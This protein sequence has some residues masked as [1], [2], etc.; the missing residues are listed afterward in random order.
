[1]SL[2]V[3]VVAAD[4]SVW[5]GDAERVV[6]RTVEG[7]IGILTGHE[8]VLAIVA[9]GNVRI[10]PTSGETINVSADGGFL[11]VADDVVHV[12]ADEAKLV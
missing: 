7:E 11:S 2:N 12:V 9:G 8:P 4:R 5:S 10:T 6:A 3:T 1:M